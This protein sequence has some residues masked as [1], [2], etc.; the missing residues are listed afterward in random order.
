MDDAEILQACLV[1]FVEPGAHEVGDLAW[2]KRVQ[3]ER[4]AERQA[5]DV[6]RSVVVVVPP[7]VLFVHLKSFK[8]TM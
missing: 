7:F 8:N 1:R 3:I 2:G 5:D 6:G 4:V